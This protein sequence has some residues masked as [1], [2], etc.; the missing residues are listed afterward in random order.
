MQKK[1][2][3]QQAKPKAKK[4]QTKTNGKNT[5]EENKK[6]VARIINILTPH[7]F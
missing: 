5:V 1:K 3:T 4:Q 2:K 7:F 6:L